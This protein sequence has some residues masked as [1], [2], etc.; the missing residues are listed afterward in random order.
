MTALVDHHYRIYGADELIKVD[1][2]QFQGMYKFF[3]KDT[4]LQL[5]TEKSVDYYDVQN[6]HIFN[7][8][9]LFFRKKKNVKTVTFYI[10]NIN[11]AIGVKLDWLH[12]NEFCG[13]GTAFS[14]YTKLEPYL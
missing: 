8:F 7:V 9:V 10:F 14:I 2:S 6:L 12:L 4:I 3:N 5:K 11:K 13:I 1:P